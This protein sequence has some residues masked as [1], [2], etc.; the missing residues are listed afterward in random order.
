MPL[1]ALSNVSKIFCLGGENVCA[2]DN[3]TLDLDPGEFVSIIGSS[4]SGKSTLM[5]ILG[6]LDTPTFRTM[7]LDGALVECATDRERAHIRNS[8]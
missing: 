7:W 3:V 8:P 4:G 1:I 6:C 5:P 2:L